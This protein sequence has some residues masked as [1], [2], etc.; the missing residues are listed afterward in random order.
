MGDPYTAVYDYNLR[1]TGAPGLARQCPALPGL[2]SQADPIPSLLLTRRYSGRQSLGKAQTPS[3]YY[4]TI[5][6]YYFFLVFSR[7][8]HPLLLENFDPV[9]SKN[10]IVIGEKWGSLAQ[11]FTN[12]IH[13]FVDTEK[14]NE[15]TC[16]H[17][18]QER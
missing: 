3:N 18:S 8:S 13:R 6:L 2:A 4:T 9:S 11:P 10:S 14:P 1:S 5:L 12:R 16:N 15:T 7:K 17:L